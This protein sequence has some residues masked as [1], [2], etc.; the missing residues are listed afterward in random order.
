VRAKSGLSENEIAD[1]ADS[2]NG[3]VG[4][5]QPERNGIEEGAAIRG[6]VEQ[7]YALAVLVQR[8]AG[9]NP[10]VAE[11]VRVHD[12]VIAGG[13]CCAVWEGI[14]TRRGNCICQPQAG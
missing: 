8:E 5:L 1:V 11:A 12:E 9:M 3:K 7:E 13:E 10:R 2:A 6:F 4:E 14:F